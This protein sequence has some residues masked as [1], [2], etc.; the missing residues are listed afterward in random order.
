[1][2]IYTFKSNT[3]DKEWDDIMSYTKLDE[4]YKEHDCRQVLSATK[5]ISESGDVHSKTSDGFKDRMKQIHKAA[6]RR[7]LMNP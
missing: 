6:G 3:S 7:S 4:Y 5:I 2:P 1:M